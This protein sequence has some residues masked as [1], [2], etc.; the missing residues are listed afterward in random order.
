M[1]IGSNRL[2][3]WVLA[4]QDEAPIT[5]S[6]VVCTSCSLATHHVKLVTPDGLLCP[7][8]LALAL[9]VSRR[10]QTDPN[11][12]AYLI[13][14]ARVDKEENVTEEKCNSDG[15]RCSNGTTRLPDD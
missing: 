8:T 3:S 6:N 14:Y 12:I 5:K 9:A 4:T 7:I 11:E 10:Y 2:Y 1:Y 13:Q 15:S